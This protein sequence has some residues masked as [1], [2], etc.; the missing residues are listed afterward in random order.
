M[1][2]KIII[3]IVIAAIALFYWYEYRPFSIK[4]NCN[5]GA[6]T[7]AAEKQKLPILEVISLHTET[8]LEEYKKENKIYDQKIYNRFYQECLRENGI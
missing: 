8:D 4:R 1:F 7:F 6:I 5:E 2:K 3:V